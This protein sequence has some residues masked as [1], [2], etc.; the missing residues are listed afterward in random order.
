MAVKARRIAILQAVLDQA[1]LSVSELA[2]QAGVS[3]HTLYAWAAGRRNPS[4][5]NLAKF[6]GALDRHGG[7]LTE[8]VG[9]L[10]EV[11][12]RI[13]NPNSKSKESSLRRLAAR[14]GYRI[15]KSRTQS[16]HSN[17]QGL[18]QVVENATNTVMV[19]ARFDADLD[20]VEW[21][22]VRS[23]GVAE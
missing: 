20:R 12:R 18:Y 23:G 19:G 14:K 16:T 22:L 1:P 11:P 8:F 21:F 2:I 6:V 10:R 4:P 3:R 7:E 15:H 9:E 17:D 13:P 5:E